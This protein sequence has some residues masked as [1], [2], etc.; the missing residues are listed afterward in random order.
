MPGEIS[1]SHSGVLFLDELP[2]FKISALEV[3]RTI[4]DLDD[5]QNTLRNI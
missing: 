1:L 2:D 3:S 5:A 4:S